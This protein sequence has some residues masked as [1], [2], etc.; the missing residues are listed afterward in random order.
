[1]L[2]GR[3]ILILEDETLLRKGLVQYLE[4]LGAQVFPA[5]TVAEA[6]RVRESTELD[7]ALLDINLPDGSGLD[8]LES[9]GFAR[10]TLVVVMTADGGTRIAIEAMKRGAHDYLAKPFEPEE[11]P[12]VFS[13]VARDNAQRRKAEF[14]R[15]ARAAPGKSLF[16]GERLQAVQ[17][18]LDRILQADQRLR[19][20]LPPVLIEGETGT[21]KSTLARWIHEHGPRR[22]APLIEINC[23]TLPEALA[24]SELFGHERGAFTD[25]RK[26]RMGLF[27]AADSGSLFL[28]EISSLSPAVQTKVLT[29]IEDGRIRRLGGNTQRSV[30]VRLIAASL[31]PLDQLVG[32][33]AFREDLYHRLNLL[34]IRVPALREFPGDIPGLAAHIL[35]QLKGRYRLPEA[36]IS[37]EGLERLMA[38]AW[39]GNVRELMHEIE[40]ALIFHEAD[41]LSFSHLGADPPPASQ[42]APASSLRNPLWKL[43]QEGFQFEEA[44]KALTLDVIRDAL[45]QE[46]GNVSAAARRLGVPRDFIRY[47]LD[48]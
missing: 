18:Q 12:M 36:A 29:A 48:P 22:D 6:R 9:P 46:G 44:L 27:E 32:E 47:R 11:L 1:M 42:S 37:R 21:G 41:S 2:T 14:E 8:L 13:R 26:E 45:D 7:F 24:E 20:C 19:T 3:Q 16:H 17:R 15:D 25:A 28:D 39:P 10:T 33:G 43:P 4:S 40:R 38:C 30:D 34:H 23:S 31:H 5:K 35:E